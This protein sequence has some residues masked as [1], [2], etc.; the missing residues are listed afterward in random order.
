MDGLVTTDP[1]SG[2][3]KTGSV[4]L[5]CASKALLVSFEDYGVCN[6]RERI[7]A[8][9]KKVADEFTNKNTSMKDLKESDYQRRRKESYQVH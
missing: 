6:M 3:M 9:K 1:T 4:G 2:S 5:M 7:A 8:K